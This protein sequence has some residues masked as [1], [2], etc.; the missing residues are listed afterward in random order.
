MAMGRILVTG[1]GG[2]LGRE[3]VPRLA[4]AGLA[5]RATG[6]RARPAGL[7][8]DI[9]WLS[10]DLVTG[11]G[12]DAALAG[13]DT[14]VHAATDPRPFG[15]QVDEAGTGRLID[16]ARAAGLGHLV[17]ISIV[18][19]DRIPYV[20]YRRKL[21]AERLVEAG[22]VPWTILRATQFHRLID[23]FLRPLTRLPVA[24]VPTDLRFQTVDTAEVAADL[25]AAVRA[26]ASGYRPAIGGPEVLTLGE[27][28]RAWLRARGE[29]RQIV[30]LPLPGGLAAGFRAGRTTC[31][32][33]RHG[34]VTWAAWLTRQ[35]GGV[36]LAE[37]SAPPPARR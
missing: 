26:G 19:I 30:H 31:P 23:L 29:R 27:M 32:D 35:Y 7:P 11:A 16:R 25:V 9:E 3:L 21:A 2:G 4:A 34:Q 33:A 1:G 28:T 37:R 13:V 14:I 10:A 17:F 20:Y 12:L 8:E 6:R 24:L 22:G 5:V 18:G 15:N 36:S